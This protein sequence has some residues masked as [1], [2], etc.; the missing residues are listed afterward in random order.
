MSCASCASGKQAEFPAEINIHCPGSENINRPSVLVFPKL[1]VCLDCGFTQFTLLET[2]LRLLT[3][4]S[5]TELP[6]Q[7]SRVNGGQ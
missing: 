2:E 3:E 6:A 7:T 1:S 5:T 4:S